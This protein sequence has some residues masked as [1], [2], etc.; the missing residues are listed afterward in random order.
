MF[1]YDQ[2]G[3]QSSLRGVREVIE[4]QGLFC[5]FYTDRGSHY[6]HTPEAGG[7]PACCLPAG[8]AGRQ[9]TGIC[10]RRIGLAITPSSP[11]HHANRD[12]PSL[13]AGTG[14]SWTMCSANILNDLPAAGRTVR[15]DNGVPFEGL[16]LPIPANRRGCHDIK[17]K[18]K[19]LRHTDGAL[20]VHHG[21][22]MLARYSAQGQKLTEDLSVAA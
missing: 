18:I 15:K 8:Q 12:Q 20:S 4:R 6:W 11:S 5:L 19:V 9:V 7:K 22:R 21:P 3:T 17:R 14:A 1:F 10:R 13:S 16:T 2:E